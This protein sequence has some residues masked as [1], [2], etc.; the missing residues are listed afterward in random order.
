MVRRRKNAAGPKPA[1]EPPVQHFGERKAAEVAP[2]P[3]VPDQHGSAAGDFYSVVPIKPV[4]MVVVQVL[5]FI[6]T[7]DTTLPP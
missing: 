2:E 6:S 5:V 3:L 7:V 1:R 4:H